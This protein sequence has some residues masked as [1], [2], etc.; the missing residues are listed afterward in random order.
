MNQTLTV[1]GQRIEVKEAT[2]YPTRL[3]LD[4]N[5]D[6]KN[7]KKVFGLSDLQLVDEQG[8]AWRTDTSTGGDERSI[9]FESM[10]FSIPKKLTLQGS[11][12]SGLDKRIWIFPLI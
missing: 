12:F 6:P 2:L 5:F 10:Y 4:V 9:Y 3:V 11:G 7:T 8:R 1:D